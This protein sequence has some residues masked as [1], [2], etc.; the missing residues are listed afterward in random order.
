MNL[1]Q[2]NYYGTG[3][4]SLKSNRTDYLKE[5]TLFEF[6]ETLHGRRH[7]EQACNVGELL[8]HVGPGTDD[9]L[10]TTQ[11]KFTPAEAPGIDEQSNYL[12]AGCGAGLD[13]RDF[14]D[15][16]HKGTYAA[17]SYT[18]YH[19]QNIPEFSFQRVSAVA[20]QYIPFWNR[21]RVIALRAATELSFHSDDQVVPFYMQAW[22]GSS[23]TLRGFRPYRFYDENSFAL[24]GEYRWEINTALEMALFA[25]FGKVFHRPGQIGFSNME[26]SGGFGFRFKGSRQVI[27]RLDTGFSHEGFEV[28]L[29]FGKLFY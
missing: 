8:I 5:T 4:D 23:Y 18:W 3:P 2:V 17:A 9:A 7:L 22:L 12:L 27:A 28:W 6:R 11:E 25:D 10:A 20:E 14:P 26:S 16:P 13:Y 15:D 21:K 29:R 24:T 1:P 19:A